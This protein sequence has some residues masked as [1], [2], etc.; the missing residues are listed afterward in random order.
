MATKEYQI[1]APDGSILRFRAPEDAPR[2]KILA[3]AKK[4]FE[5]KAQ[6][7][8]Q[9]RAQ[10][11]L[12]TKQAPAQRSRGRR[13]KAQ[14]AQSK[15]AA[16]RE[17]YLSELEKTN[18]FQAQALREMGPG[19]RMLI[20]AGAGFADILTG[21]GLRDRQAGE[22][23]AIEQISKSGDSFDIGRTI[24]QAA[25]FAGLG[26]AAGAATKGAPLAAKALTQ[27]AIGAT[28]G[29]SIARGTGG[30]AL[31]V[32]TGAIL[33][34]AIGGGDEA[35]S[36]AS[37]R[38]G[39]WVVGLGVG[40]PPAGSLI[41]EAGRRTP[42]F[43]EALEQSGQSFDDLVQEA[44][45]EVKGESVESIV[46]AGRKDDF[47]R[48]VDDVEVDPQRLAAAE[49][50]GLGD[51][52]P[53]SVLTEDQATQELAGALAAVQGTRASS[54]LDAFTKEFGHRADQYIEEI[55]GS[56]DR[57]SITQNLLD[58]MQSDISRIKALENRLY[59]PIDDTIGMGTQVKDY[60]SSLKNRLEAK[61]R[62]SGGISRLPRHEEEMLEML[63]SKEG[64]TYQNLVDKMRQ[65]GNAAYRKNSSFDDIDTASLKRMYTDLTKVRDNAAEV[66]GVGNKM[67][68]AKSLGQQRFALQESTEALFGKELN[69]SIFPKIDS[70]VKGLAKGSVREFQAAMDSIPA[71]HRKADAATMLNKA[72]TGGR[73]Q[74]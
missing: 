35:L 66:F 63:K 47:V 46:S 41:D 73:E 29:G 7:Q 27:G 60:A 6:D 18:P 64:M 22:L 67:K 61:A 72:M 4:Q 58:N 3:F 42:E 52:A 10:Q 9:G 48:V 25:P 38:G 33:G 40:Q 45:R 55:G 8:S 74:S 65:I 68:R 54:A 11:E 13:A 28:E 5:L 34:G 51:Q 32:A 39:R 70:S 23:E 12:P 44:S 53:V 24:G 19:E 59:Q 71:K 49:S 17:A 21:I 36:P 2:E 57:G 31:D 37:H 30:D 56:I 14:S 69:K 43:S 1:K 15:R 16:D 20:G 50:I 26:V 62:N